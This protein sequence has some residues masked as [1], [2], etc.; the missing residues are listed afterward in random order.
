M[1]HHR[2]FVGQRPF[3][4]DND[5]AAAVQRQWAAIQ[6]AV[7]G[8]ELEGRPGEHP[9]E[10]GERVD[11]RL[12]PQL[13]AAPIR[14][15]HCHLHGITTS[16]LVEA[17]FLRYQ[18]AVLAS[19]NAK[20]LEPTD[21][22]IAVHQLQQ[23]ASTRP[24]CP[25]NLVQHQLVLGI[26]LEVAEGGEDVDDRVELVHERDLPHVA[27][28][29]V[30]LHA[31]SHCL[32]SCSIQEDL[33]QILAGDSV[34]SLGEG[35]GMPSMA[36]G[37]VEDMAAWRQGQEFHD[38]LDLTR[39]AFVREHRAINVE[40]LLTKE[41]RVPRSCGHPRIGVL[42]RAVAHFRSP[43]QPATASSSASSYLVAPLR[44]A[45]ASLVAAA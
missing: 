42:P 21:Q 32:S 34:P 16:A 13:A 20:R 28:D 12:V 31:A 3:L 39:G 36:A 40:V 11:P 25:V 29:P 15:N 10:F 6:S 33:T 22:C 5:Q 27:V 45:A 14:I 18:E 23:Q 26:A 30:H 43:H 9:C 2:R 24:Q 38:A 8:L 7:D 17:A 35:D 37:E 1:R 41:A 44:P 4:G 19:A